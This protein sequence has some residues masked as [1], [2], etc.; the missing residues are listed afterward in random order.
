MIGEKILGYTVDEKIGSGGFGTVYR[1]FKTNASG[2]YI[3][4]IKHMTIPNQKQYA[5]VLNSMG[6]DYS[7]ADDY[8][9]GVLK[10]IVNEIQIIST[11]SEAGTQNIVRYYENDIVESDSPKRYDIYIL[12]EC[13][14]PF[15]EYMYQ[16]E[17]RVKDVIKLGQDILT[18]LVSC[19]EKNIIHRDIKDD[20]I[21]VSV[22]GV[23]KLGD[24]GV[25]KI[26][27]DRSRAESM[28]GTPNFIAPEVYL[29]KEKY[30]ATVDI[31]SLGIVLY[32][33]LN[34]SRNPFL[35]AFPQS[36]DSNDEDV[37]FEKRMNGDVPELPCDAKNALGEAIL[38][39]IKVRN[40]RYDSA[41]AFLYALEQAEKELTDEE[42]NK[43]VNTVIVSSQD[44]IKKENGTNAM[45]ETIGTDADVSI[46]KPEKNTEDSNLFET[47]SDTYN[48]TPV[49][50]EPVINIKGE[51]PNRSAV[52]Q[53]KILQSSSEQE[54]R[55]IKMTYKEPQRVEVV[56]KSDFRWVAF[57][58]PVIV[59]AIY[60]VF[61]LVVLPNVYGKEISVGQWLFN[62]PEEVL[63]ILQD[64]NTVFIP[65]YKIWGIKIGMYILWI[66]FVM[67]LFNLGRV[68]QNK[69]PE[70]NVNAL[71]RD[72]EPYLKAMEINEAIKASYCKEAMSAKTAF[73]NITEKL[74]NE[75]DFGIG[76]DSLIKCES[77][78]IK[79]LR[80]IEG[81]IQALYDEKTAKDAGA[82]IEANCKTIQTKLKMRIE[83]KKK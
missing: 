33:L 70:Y 73:R 16:H 53:S 63:E 22:N 74:K 35:P 5:D 68:L 27:K 37:A 8:F 51:I 52:K 47:V 6:G 14:K 49:V 26:L 76:N 60:I 9:A 29:G 65:I 83:M 34:R 61:Y 1:V 72:N 10:E 80:E 46:R 58:L 78:I 79:C 50:T 17:L 44:A 38:P 25:S 41:K 21:F 56:N 30:D 11:L 39:S 77:D 3:R 23:F 24:F 55:L 7:K 67:S 32:K 18:A 64:K 20:N 42:L 82:V 28:K 71:M 40:Q 31:Y 12:M 36:Y 57:V 75:S 4:A 66:F 45:D 62:N 19:H 48:K 59:L 69:K 13:L 81:N 15:T 2:T 43:V 54:N